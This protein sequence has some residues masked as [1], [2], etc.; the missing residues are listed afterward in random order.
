MEVEPTF[1]ARVFEA[2]WQHTDVEISKFVRRARGLHTLFHVSSVH[3]LELVFLVLGRLPDWWWLPPVGSCYW[4]NA[5][6][7]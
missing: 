6:A 7:V 2:T 4:M 1:L 5:T 3:G